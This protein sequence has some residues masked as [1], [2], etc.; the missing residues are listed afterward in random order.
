M[1]H[2]YRVDVNDATLMTIALK[3]VKHVSDYKF[4]DVTLYGKF[5]FLKLVNE[6]SS[7]LSKTTRRIYTLRNCL[8]SEIHF[9]D[10]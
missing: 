7:K 5:T 1:I 4:L 3:S 10:Y 9:S 2:Q 6:A 8:S